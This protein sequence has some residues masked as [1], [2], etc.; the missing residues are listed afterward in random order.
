MRSSQL[1]LCPKEQTQ[2]RNWFDFLFIHFLLICDLKNAWVQYTR[3]AEKIQSA[4]KY[5]IH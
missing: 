2:I 3:R 5:K 4:D 1:R